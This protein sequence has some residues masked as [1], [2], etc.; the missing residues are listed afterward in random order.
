M[1]RVILFLLVALA[2]PALAAPPNVLLILSDDQAYTDYG[3][4]GHGVIQTPRIDQLAKD[5]V[6]TSASK[7]AA[8]GTNRCMTSSHLAGTSRSLSG[9]PRCSLISRTIRRSGC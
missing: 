3:C 5:G 6:E 9:T 1:N 4:M 2:S 8:K 7:S